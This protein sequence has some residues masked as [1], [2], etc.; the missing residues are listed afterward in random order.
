MFVFIPGSIRPVRFG[1]AGTVPAEKS[2]T[3]VTY[4]NYLKGL[5]KSFFRVKV[6]Q[7]YTQCMQILY[8]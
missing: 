8:T 6:A 2:I 1:S 5:L 3:T 4:T 7:S